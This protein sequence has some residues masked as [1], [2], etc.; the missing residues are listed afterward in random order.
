M[1]AGF[2]GA[3]VAGNPDTQREGIIAKVAFAKPA[4]AI[5]IRF[6]DVSAR[7]QASDVDPLAIESL[8]VDIFPACLKALEVT[9]VFWV[10]PGAGEVS[11]IVAQTIGLF[12]AAPC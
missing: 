6:Q 7:L 5:H 8:V 9:V 12:G 3:D 10:L 4:A 1:P 2:A 11:I